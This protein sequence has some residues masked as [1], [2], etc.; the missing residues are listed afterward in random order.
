[1]V[2]AAPPQTFL[3]NAP[4][5]ARVVA[6]DLTGATFNT[7]CHTT[8]QAKALLNSGLS[9]LALCQQTVPNMTAASLTAALIEPDR[10]AIHAA[11]TAGQVTPAQ[12]ADSLATLQARLSAW[13]TTPGGK[14]K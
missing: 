6:P 12:E 13:V 4:T 3:L 7:V 14:V 11:V 8:T 1:M 2:A 9:P 5:T 10:T